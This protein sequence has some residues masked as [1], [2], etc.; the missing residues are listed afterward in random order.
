MKIELS[1]KELEIIAVA[2]LSADMIDAMGDRYRN[3]YYEWKIYNRL[4]KEKIPNGIYYVGPEVKKK[5]RVLFPVGG[6]TPGHG[7]KSWK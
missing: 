3:S 5:E 7:G 2:L 6:V 1:K 4:L